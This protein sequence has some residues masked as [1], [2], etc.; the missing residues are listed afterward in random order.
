MKPMFGLGL[1]G[2]ERGEGLRHEGAVRAGVDVLDHRVLLARVEGGRPV[3]HPPDVR[4][5]VAALCR[6]DL[7]RPPAGLLERREIDALE[8]GD[9]RAVRRPAQF[10]NRPLVDARVDVDEEGAVFR[11]AGRVV[12]LRFGQTREA[13][14]VEVDAVVVD[15]V[16]V[17]A[18]VHPAPAEPD[19]PLLIVDARDA[20]DHPLAPGD[21]VLHRARHAVE[22][23]E[24]VPAV[25]L[26]HPDD[27]AAVGRRRAGTSCPNR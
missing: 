15:E 8:F 13:R 23:I 27:L 2:A 21:L 9:Q 14:P 20:A 16:R 18:G 6:E 19:L 5:P 17:L 11:E 24:V 25:P 7:R 1:H 3:D 4:L 22:E 10:R 12:G 26:R